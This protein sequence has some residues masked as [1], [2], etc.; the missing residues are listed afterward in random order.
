MKN[1]NLLLEEYHHLENTTIVISC[2]D[3]EVLK[4]FAFRAV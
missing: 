2:Q 3:T 1:K 4:I